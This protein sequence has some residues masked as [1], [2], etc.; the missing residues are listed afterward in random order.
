MAETAEPQFPL[1]GLAVPGRARF[2]DGEAGVTLAERRPGSFCE[3]ACWPDARD[4]LAAALKVRSLPQPGRLATTRTYTLL[5]LGPGRFQA[6]A[7]KPGLDGRLA[8]AVT[9][10]VGAVVDLSQARGGLRLSG[11]AAQDVLQKGLDFDLAPA[12]FPVG[13]AAAGTIHHMPV[14]LARIDA[15]AFDLFTFRGFAQS[16]WE[17]SVDRALEY[18]WRAAAPIV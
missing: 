5:G 2:V 3:V 6:I 18:G 9:S 14:T 1:A 10:D 11:P 17:W 7:E 8:T 4:R 16:L 12:A 13:A 15:E